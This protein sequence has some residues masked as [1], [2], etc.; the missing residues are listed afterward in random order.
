MSFKTLSF[1]PIFGKYGR[2]TWFGHQDEGG[3]VEFFMI[4]KT[5]TGDWDLHIAFW[6]NSKQQISIKNMAEGINRASFMLNNPGVEYN[7]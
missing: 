7:A 6:D 5:R 2:E 4:T 3:L 1:I